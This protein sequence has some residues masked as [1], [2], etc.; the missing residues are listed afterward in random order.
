[1]ELDLVALNTA[2]WLEHS[3]SLDVYR[4]RER[5]SDPDSDHLVYRSDHDRFQWVRHT[6]PA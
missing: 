1:M 6:P 4:E 5:G 3:P 2:L